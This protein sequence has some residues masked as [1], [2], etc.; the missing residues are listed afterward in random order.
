MLLSTHGPVSWFD[1]ETPVDVTQSDDE[2]VAELRELIREDGPREASSSFAR[3]IQ[4]LGSKLQHPQ[5]H[6]FGRAL[7]EEVWLEGFAVCDAQ[8]S[9]GCFHEF[10]GLAI[11][12]RGPDV[13]RTLNEGCIQQG[14]G[15]LGCQHG[16][17]HGVLAYAGYRDKDL[18]EA[19]SLCRDLKQSDPIGGCYGGMYMEYNLHTMKGS[20]ARSRPYTYSD[21][22]KPCSET[23]DLE[24]RR[25]CLYWQPQWW[26]QATRVPDSEES[27]EMMG[28][29]CRE[30]KNLLSVD[31]ECFRGIGNITSAAANFVPERAVELCTIATQNTDELFWCI[32]IVANHLNTEASPE[33]ARSVCTVFDEASAKH[34]TCLRWA[35]NTFNIVNPQ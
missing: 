21:R 35:N 8:F 34:E 33:A 23:S 24:I 12:E 11:E 29:F 30:A 10:I 13:I 31:R 22:F 19:M 17:G 18:A 3:S 28:R 7:Y 15:N 26:N 32:S 14:S 25:S 6:L 16:I 2:R 20:D 1:R 27:F 9:F 5:A 4:S